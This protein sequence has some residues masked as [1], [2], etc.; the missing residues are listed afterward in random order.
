MG[1]GDASPRNLSM[2]FTLKAPGVSISP[3]EILLWRIS[4]KRS[5]VSKGESGS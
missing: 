4:R 2:A 5:K 3:R 1:K